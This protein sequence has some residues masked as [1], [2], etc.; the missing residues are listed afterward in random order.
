MAPGIRAAPITALFYDTRQNMSHPVSA[1]LDQLGVPHTFGPTEEYRSTHATRLRKEGLQVVD[2]TYSPGQRVQYLLD[3]LPSMAATAPMALVLDTDVVPLCTPSELVELRAA[4]V[5][6]EHAPANSVIVS[7][8]KNL[9]PP[10]QSFDGTMLS[11]HHQSPYPAA[12]ENAPL[13]YINSGVMLGRP[14]DIWQMYRCME[15]RFPHF[16]EKCPGGHERK[17]KNY[18]FYSRTQSGGNYH[19]LKLANGNWGWD[20]A[21][22]HM[23]YLEQLAAR[24]PTECPPLVLDRR[25]DLALHMSKIPHAKISFR[26]DRRVHFQ[27]SRVNVSRPCFLHANG[28]SKLWNGPLLRWWWRPSVDLPRGFGNGKRT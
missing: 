20:Q 17:S 8:E 9:W 2:E 5:A 21:C 7:A 12:T 26:S 4:I 14:I 11:N 16:P 22:F 28:P 24:L 10:Y 27:A 6:R 23:Y 13:R 15:R 19:G 3:V 18:T 1:M 25:A